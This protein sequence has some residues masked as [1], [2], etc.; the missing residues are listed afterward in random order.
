MEKQKV[1][2]VSPVCPSCE[3]VK[4]HL[5]KQG[6]LDKYIIVDA[7]TPEGLDFA[8]RLG[9]R[10]VPQC[11]IIEGEGEK[12]TVRICSDEEWKRMMKGDER[13]T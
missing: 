11:A 7:S 12:K 2:I 3:V 8:R 6:T 4:K 13:E 1:L 9:I 10:G 5:A